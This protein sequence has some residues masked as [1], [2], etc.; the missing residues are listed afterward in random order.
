M[1]MLPMKHP[2]LGELSVYG[3]GHHC[4][5][6]LGFILVAKWKN[7]RVRPRLRFWGKLEPGGQRETWLPRVFE[8]QNR[9]GLGS[10]EGMRESVS[11]QKEKQHRGLL[12]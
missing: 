9:A 7:S 1:I 6:L 11:L 10:P 8:F 2:K 5:M 3:G 12:F 4:I